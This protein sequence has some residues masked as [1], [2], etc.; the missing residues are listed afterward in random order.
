MR[1]LDFG[2]ILSLLGIFGAFLNIM[3]RRSCFIVWFFSNI[4]WLI[5]GFLTSEMRVQIPLWG[6]FILLNI[7][8]YFKWGRKGICKGDICMPI[9]TFFIQRYCDRC[10]RELGGRR[11]LSFFT[12]DV[13]CADCSSEEE[14]IRKRI[15]E[16]DGDPNADLRYQNIGFLP[17]LK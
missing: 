6:I 12:S 13:I 4:G 11:S 16:E 10:N 5:L 15:R 17:K 1:V 9:Q 8:G 3:G 2:W 14:E 7:W